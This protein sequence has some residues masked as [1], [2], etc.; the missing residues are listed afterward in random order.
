MWTQNLT[1]STGTWRVES[2]FIAGSPASPRSCARR[3]AN[4]PVSMRPTHVKG[5]A[6]QTCRRRARKVGKTWSVC[7]S[8]RRSTQVQRCSDRYTERSCVRFPEFGKSRER[9]KISEGRSPAGSHSKC[10][11]RR[12]IYGRQ[13]RDSNTAQYDSTPSVAQDKSECGWLTVRWTWPAATLSCSI[14]CQRMAR[15]AAIAKSRR[16][17]ATCGS[18]RRTGAQIGSR[19]RRCSRQSTRGG[20]PSGKRDDG[21][22]RRTASFVGGVGGRTRGWC[23]SRRDTP[24]RARGRLRDKRG[25]DG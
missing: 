24:V 18:L 6:R 2:A 1:R 13:H 22:A 11:E 16:M 12:E 20:R 25:Y 10:P 15:A 21:S 7:I 19:S 3:T 5:H 8:E 4:N 17:S 9:D 23:W 14:G